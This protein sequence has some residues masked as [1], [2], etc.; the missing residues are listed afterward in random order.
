MIEPRFLHKIERLHL[1][2]VKA[3]GLQNLTGNLRYYSYR[4][5]AAVKPAIEEILAHRK[6]LRQAQNVEQMMGHVC[7]ASGDGARWDGI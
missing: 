2:A 1:N 6:T 3:A 5:N 7:S 4:G